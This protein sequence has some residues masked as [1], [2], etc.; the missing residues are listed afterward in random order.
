MGSEIVLMD[1]E[2][3][4]SLTLKPNSFSELR[5]R[6]RQDLEEWIKQNPDILGTELLL[7]TRSYFKTLRKTIIKQAI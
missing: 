5:V 6:E 4:K 7:I 1:P 2:A 3:G